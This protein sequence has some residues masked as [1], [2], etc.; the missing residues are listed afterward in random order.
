MGFQQAKIFHLKEISIKI[1]KIKGLLRK[2]KTQIDGIRAFLTSV[3]ILASRVKLIGNLYLLLFHWFR[4]NLGLTSDFAGV[5]D[6]FFFE[7]PCW[8]VW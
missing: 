1:L 7:V 2:I 5:F 4:P 8:S 3:F 6:D